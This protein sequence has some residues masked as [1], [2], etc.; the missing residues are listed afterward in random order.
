MALVDVTI[1]QEARP[2]SSQ[3]LDLLHESPYL[4]DR[5]AQSDD[6][7]WLRTSENVHPSR[8]QNGKYIHLQALFGNTIVALPARL[9]RADIFGF[10]QGPGGNPTT[11]F[12]WTMAWGHNNN[13][14][15]GDDGERPPPV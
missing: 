2:A 14:M 12:L 11:T 10:A 7:A 6:R 15:G 5:A 1:V 13:N 9:S 3:A 4:V 8:W